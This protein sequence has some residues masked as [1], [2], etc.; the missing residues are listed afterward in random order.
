ACTSAT[1]E[2]SFVLKAM[3]C[4][5]EDAHSSLRISLGRYTTKGDVDMAIESFTQAVTGLRTAK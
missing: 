4:S 2:P 1:V 3:G 5:D